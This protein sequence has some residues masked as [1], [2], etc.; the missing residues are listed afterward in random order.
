MCNTSYQFSRSEKTGMLS[1]GITVNKFQQNLND[2]FSGGTIFSKSASTGF[3]FICSAPSL[4]CLLLKVVNPR[5][6]VG[7]CHHG[8]GGPWYD[9]VPGPLPVFNPAR[10]WAIRVKNTPSRPM[11]SSTL[12]HG[13]SP[14]PCLDAPQTIVRA[15]AN[16]R[17]ERLSSHFTRK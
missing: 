15:C 4:P 10:E 5:W 12:D 11:P 8:L 16:R 6:Y 9:N 2:T 3:L 17:E 7:T 1:Y 13:P 14:R